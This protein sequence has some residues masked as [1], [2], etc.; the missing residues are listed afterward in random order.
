MDESMIRPTNGQKDDAV[1]DPGDDLVDSYTPELYDANISIS[2]RLKAR[3]VDKMSAKRSP[4]SL[5]QNIK[6]DED[7]PIEPG[8]PVRSLEVFMSVECY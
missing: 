2:T 6:T 1:D 7:E 4:F 3:L 5:P 8:E